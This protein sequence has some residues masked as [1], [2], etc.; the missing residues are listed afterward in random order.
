[1]VWARTR[2]ARAAAPFKIGMITMLSDP[3]GPCGDPE[4]I[5]A[6]PEVR[7]AYLDEGSG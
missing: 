5:D 7:T 3:A 6:D 1:M 4:A 2:G